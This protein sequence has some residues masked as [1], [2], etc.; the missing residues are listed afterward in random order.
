MISVVKTEDLF[1]VT[2]IG[3]RQ[4]PGIIVHHSGG[5]DD[6]ESPKYFRG[7][8]G[9]LYGEQ[10]DKFHRKVKNWSNG[11]GYHILINPG[12]EIQAGDRWLYQMNGAHC[13]IR[14]HW[15]GVCFVGNFNWWKPTEQQLQS[16]RNIKAYFPGLPV[17]PHGKHKKTMCPGRRIS[18]NYWY[19]EIDI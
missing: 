10:F 16:W 4:W 19:R 2:R 7:K 1:R 15:L 5:K 6:S 13:P 17:E 18:V 9:K 11:L 14:N 12:G 3:I 8:I